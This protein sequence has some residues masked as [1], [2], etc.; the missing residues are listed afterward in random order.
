[1]NR[2]DSRDAGAQAAQAAPKAEREAGA[3]TE[4]RGQDGSEARPSWISWIE[5]VEADLRG[6][7]KRQCDDRGDNDG[8]S[9]VDFG[10]ADDP[11]CIMPPRQRRGR[12]S[13][14][15]LTCP[16]PG[17]SA[18]VTGTIPIRFGQHARALRRLAR[19]RRHRASPR[20]AIV[21]APVNGHKR[22][23]YPLETGITQLCNYDFDFIYGY[24]VFTN[25]ARRLV[26]LRVTVSRARTTAASPAVSSCQCALQ[27][28]R[29]AR[30]A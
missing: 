9:L 15:P 5:A 13:P 29:A 23:P 21:D 7:A 18:S 14:M 11:G 20:L 22:R 28:G 6:P 3:A 4:G 30:P 10:S 16:N 1:M 24:A 25:G 8:D 19:R 12:T 27:R 26:G 2:A 17:G